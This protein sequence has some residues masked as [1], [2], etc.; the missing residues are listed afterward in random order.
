MP[1][2]CG[3]RRPD[4]ADRAHQQRHR[5]VPRRHRGAAG[6]I[7]HRLAVIRVRHVEEHDLAL[8]LRPRASRARRRSPPPSPRPRCPAGGVATLPP[9]PEHRDDVMRRIGD[10]E[11]LGAA[12]PLRNHHAL[13]VHVLEAVLLHGLDGPRDGAIE[14]L[15][16]AEALAVGVGQLGEAIPRELIGLAAAISLPALARKGSSQEVC[17]AVSVVMRRTQESSGASGQV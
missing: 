7:R 1:P 15:G 14:I 8:G 5:A 4:R 6:S 9:R 2:V 12:H 11:A 13:G 16:A 10:L 3:V 17:D